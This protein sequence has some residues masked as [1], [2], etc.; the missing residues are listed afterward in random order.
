MFI[1]T[2]D[3]SLVPSVPFSSEDIDDKLSW[4]SHV[5]GLK[6]N[7]TSKLSLIK[8]CRFLPK[9]VLLYT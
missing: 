4:S 6:K 3:R 1:S 2:E 8:K 7:V 9:H 5:S